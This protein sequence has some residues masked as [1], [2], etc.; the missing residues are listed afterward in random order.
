MKHVLAVGLIT[1]VCWSSA[2]AFAK[3]STAKAKPKATGSR[4]LIFDA[5]DPKARPTFYYEVETPDRVSAAPILFTTMLPAATSDA[6]KAADT[7]D[8]SSISVSEK[9]M[10]LD[11]AKT[12]TTKDDKKSKANRAKDKEA[13]GDGAENK[14]EK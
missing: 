6:A 2:P 11:Q 8:S 1:S 9:S 5:S 12:S 3:S 10:I 4:V 14:L 7:D 13:G